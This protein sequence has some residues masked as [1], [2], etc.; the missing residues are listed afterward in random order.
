MKP[1]NKLKHADFS[2]EHALRRKL[3]E[4]ERAELFWSRMGSAASVNNAYSNGEQ[5]GKLQRSPTKTST[6]QLKREL[7]EKDD[8]LQRKDAE[9]QH[10]QRIIEEKDA[11][12][13]KLR[14]EIHELKCVVQQTASKTSILSTIQ[15]ESAMAV[16]SKPRKAIRT[17]RKEKRMAVS[18]ESSSKAEEE[19]KKE[20][21]RHPKD[22]R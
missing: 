16:N 8:F 22:F 11:E 13:T 17:S 21:Q 1:G 12:L 18:G 6:T 19:T 14:K 2:A 10:R 7:K 15:E 20:L 5:N 3:I 4:T 9:L